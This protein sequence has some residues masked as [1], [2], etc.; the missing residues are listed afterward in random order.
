MKLISAT[1]LVNDFHYVWARTFLYFF[2]FNLNIFI[3]GL[4]SC[5][6]ENNSLDQIKMVK[7]FPDITRIASGKLKQ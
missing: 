6:F 5:W 3:L 2:S 1:Q 7:Y 4:G